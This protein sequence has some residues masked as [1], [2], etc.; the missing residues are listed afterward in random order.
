MILI[1]GATGRVGGLITRSLLARGESVRALVRN[2]SECGWLTAAGATLAVGD[3]RS[4]ES[5]ADACV[6]VSAVISTATSMSRGGEDTLEAV[7][8]AGNLN[9]IDA[10]A[11]HGIERFIFVSALGAAAES[12]MPLLSAKGEAEAHLR[13]SGIAAT[14]LQP[15]FYMEMLPVAVIGAPALAGEPVTLVG[16]GRRRHSLVSMTDVAAYAVAALDHDEAAGQTLAIGG[17]EPASW[18]DVVA[19]FEHELGRE[20]PV[21]YVPLGAE[22]PGMDPLLVGL[23]SALEMYDSPLE[24]GALTDRFGVQPTSLEDFVHSFVVG[25]SAERQPQAG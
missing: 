17:P 22:V 6:G 20:I 2:P 13:E 12:P 8:R 24:M 21:N 18:H 7:D 10:A 23:L 25:A 14:I 5:L 1:V 9:L 16:E 19:A 11:E 3:L 4:P 15:D